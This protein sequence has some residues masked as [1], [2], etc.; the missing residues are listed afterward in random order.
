MIY[1]THISTGYGHVLHAA[2]IASVCCIVFSTPVFAGGTAEP[3]NKTTAQAPSRAIK[4][5]PSEQMAH[6]VVTGA[7]GPWGT[8]QVWL[9]RS[10]EGEDMPFVGR[11]A[12]LNSHV[13]SMPPVIHPLPPPDEPP[14][15]FTMNVSAVIFRNVDSAPDKELIVLYS[16][17]QIGPQ[18]SQ[19]FSVCVYKWD[20]SAFVRLA[21]AEERLDGARTSAEIVKRLANKSVGGKK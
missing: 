15:F 12:V 6:K 4:L 3:L 8:A 17:V 19:Y 10:S 14:G 13:S 21:D 1:S 20:G 5:L 2:F 9:T 18:H 7:L 11:V 16:A